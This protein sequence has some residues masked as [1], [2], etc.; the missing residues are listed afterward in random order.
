[1]SFSWL[2]I[3]VEDGSVFPTLLKFSSRCHSVTKPS[4]VFIP[5]A[6]GRYKLY[7]SGKC[8]GLVPPP[9]G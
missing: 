1:M 7:G 8:D 6:N 4:H 3:S 5:A 9:A 2:P